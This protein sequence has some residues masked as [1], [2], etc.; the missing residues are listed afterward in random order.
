MPFCFP[1]LYFIYIVYVFFSLNIIGLCV[2][3][4]YCVGLLGLQLMQVA[5]CSMLDLC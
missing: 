2:G 3:A 5:C 4:N 1:L